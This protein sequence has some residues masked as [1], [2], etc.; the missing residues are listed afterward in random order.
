MMEQVYSAAGPILTR[1]TPNALVVICTGIGTL[2]G[3]FMRSSCRFFLSS[4]DICSLRAALRAPSTS[5]EDGELE[6]SVNCNDEE[7]GV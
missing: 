6:L 4:T 1:A 7:G 5:L 3:F 2:T